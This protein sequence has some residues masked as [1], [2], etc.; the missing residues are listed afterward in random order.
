M[1]LLELYEP[2]FE[3]ICVL[4]RLQRAGDGEAADYEALRAN[5][6]SLLESID[7]RAALEPLVAIEAAKLKLPI[8]FFTDSMLAESKLPSAAE[9]HQNRLAFEENQLAGDE[10]FYDLLDE[11]LADPSSE[12]TE[13]LKVFYVCLGLGF[14]GWY[15]GQPEYLRRKMET[16]ARRISVSRDRERLARLC[17]EAY[18][19]LD[20]RN[21]IEPPAGKIGAILVFFLLLSLVVAAVNIYLFR[22]GTQGFAQSLQEILRHD[23]TP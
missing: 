18:Q 17:P 1:T 15:S 7:K 6:V 13:R 16:I 12:A 23:L 11:T 9:W 5:I 20:G 14:V 4:N 19:Y 3:Y 21:L 10:K 8:L 2:L 22:L